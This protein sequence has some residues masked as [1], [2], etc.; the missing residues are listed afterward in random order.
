M[1]VIE[2]IDTIQH[3]EDVDIEVCHGMYTYAT[4][5][6]DDLLDG[7]AL[8][9]KDE[10]EQFHDTILMSRVNKVVVYTTEAPSSVTLI[11]EV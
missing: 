8:K 1:T 7:Y 10:Y 4:S 5:Y 9:C 3:D 11:V 2:F 6:Y